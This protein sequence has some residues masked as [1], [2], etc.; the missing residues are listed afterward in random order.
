M[1]RATVVLGGAALAVACSRNGTPDRA[2]RPGAS[3]SATLAM[4]APA[5]PPDAAPRSERCRVDPSGGVP[6][7]IR[8]SSRDFRIG[9]AGTMALV[10]WIEPPSP[11]GGARRVVG[12]QYDGERRALDG[13]DRVLEDTEY[14]DVIPSGAVPLSLRGSLSAV[15]CVNVAPAGVLRCSRVDLDGKDS[16]LFRL[17]FGNDGPQEPGI[18]AVASGDDAIIFLPEGGDGEVAIFATQISAARK[19]HAFASSLH[20]NPHA[21][22]LAAAR[23]SADEVAVVY[24]RGGVIRGRRAGLDEKWHGAAMTLS[25]PRTMVGAPAI[26][27]NRGDTIVLFSAREKASDPWTITRARWAGGALDLAPLLADAEQSQAPAL[28]ESDEPGCFLVAW[29]S[30]SGSATR[31]RAGRMCNGQVK[32]ATIAQLSGELIEG[33]RAAFAS[34]AAATFVVWQE[35]PKG[36]PSELRVGRFECR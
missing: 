17:S 9:A 5:A 12:R 6:I 13:P 1:R 19:S 34:S 22:A 18:A 29:V 11:Q 4:S 33:G 30:G 21:E 27:S 20:G 8:A 35:F 26:A 31:T 2:T 28:L 23:V 25:A 16:P 7:P 32:E 36:K 14:G 24:R 10:T 15:Q 3:A